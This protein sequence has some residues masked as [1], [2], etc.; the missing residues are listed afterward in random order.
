MTAV[1]GD[2]DVRRMGKMMV[3]RCAL[4][5]LVCAGSNLKSLRL[6]YAALPVGNLLHKE[7][8]AMGQQQLKGLPL[9]GGKGH[10]SRAGQFP[11]RS[12]ERK[13][14]FGIGWEEAAHVSGNPNEPL[15]RPLPARL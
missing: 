1:R 13:V 10:K 15:P 2:K 11:E 4:L 6:R 5:N 12:G 9:T 7:R 3:P 14:M 8:K